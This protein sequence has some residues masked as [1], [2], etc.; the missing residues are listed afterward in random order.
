MAITPDG[1]TA[2]VTEPIKKVVTILDLENG[3][4][5]ELENPYGWSSPLGIALDA[6]NDMIAVADRSTISVFKAGSARLLFSTSGKEGLVKP[7]DVAFDPGRRRIYVVDIGTHTL[8]SFDYEGKFLSTMATQGHEPGQVYFP[9]G[10]AVDSEGDIFVVDMMNFRLQIFGPDGKHIKVIG[11]HGD[12]PGQFA[13]PKA[14][15]ISKDG[16]VLVTDAAFNNLQLFDK[17]GN[18]Y[19]GVGEGGGA[20]GQFQNPQ[21]ILIDDA[22]KIYVVDSVNRRL[23]IFQLMDDKY[24]EEHPE[25]AAKAEA[26]SQSGQGDKKEKALQSTGKPAPE[27]Q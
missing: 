18:V 7:V 5:K 13:R 3:T 8:T 21:G 14:V 16:Y 6:E 23:Q 20:P 26:A 4:S 2:Y 24:Y 9:A 17:K 12:A 1:K 22:H 19:L 10:V 11:E 25:E 15:A 27:K